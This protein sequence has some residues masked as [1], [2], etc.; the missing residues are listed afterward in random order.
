MQVDSDVEGGIDIE[1]ECVHG[2]LI[3][4][5]APSYQIESSLNDVDMTYEL[6]Q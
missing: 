6:L 5:Q 4:I 3:F 1:S 2:H